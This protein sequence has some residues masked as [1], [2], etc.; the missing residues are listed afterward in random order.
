MGAGSLRPHTDTLNIAEHLEQM[1]K[2]VMVSPWNLKNSRSLVSPTSRVSGLQEMNR[3][4]NPLKDLPPTL[5]GLHCCDK[6]FSE[7]TLEGVSC[8]CVNLQ[9][10]GAREGPELCIPQVTHACVW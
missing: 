1:T 10:S 4:R 8:Q 2:T 3:D 6:Y 5:R 7:S 9:V